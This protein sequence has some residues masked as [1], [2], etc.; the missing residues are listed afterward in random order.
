VHALVRDLV[1][2]CLAEVAGGVAL[3]QR[4]TSV[5]VADAVGVLHEAILKGNGEAAALGDL[6]K[7]PEQ[8]I[9]AVA[10][11][12]VDGERGEVRAVRISRIKDVPGAETEG[13]HSVV[14]RVGLALDRSGAQ[15]GDT[16]GALHD[17]TAHGLPGAI[18]GDARGVGALH[19]N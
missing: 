1:T 18:A 10:L 2:Q 11:D 9:I 15:D 12:G 17:L 8:G 13:D 19:G 4:D 6:D 16:L 14:A 7:L 5:A 3:L